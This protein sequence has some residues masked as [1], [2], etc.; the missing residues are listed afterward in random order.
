MPQGYDSLVG[1]RG[2]ALSGGE[3]QR[4]SIAR[5]LLIDPRNWPKFQ[6]GADISGH[7]PNAFFV[8]DSTGRY[9]DI[10]KQIGIGQPMVTRGIA[11]ADVD[12]D[13]DLDFVFANQWE[14]SSF[15]RNDS[16]N[17]GAFLALALRLPLQE[18]GTPRIVP[19]PLSG[20]PASVPAIGAAA[21][22]VLPDGRRMSALV[23]GG[24]GHSGKRAPNLHFGLGAMA[25]D[26]ALKLEVRWRDRDG[27]QRQHSF[28]ITPGWHTLL[29]G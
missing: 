10:A 8:R 16:P 26:Q 2:Q 24:N 15:Y 14:N 12:G 7:E 6:P 1:E 18:T 29:L 13:G 19:G 4:I 28:D 25:P 9:C 3:R 17:P 27:R 5:A 23:D 11:I 21:T 20:L 22:L